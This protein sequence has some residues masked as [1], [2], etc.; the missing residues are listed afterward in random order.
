MTRGGD[1]DLWP[2][3]ISWTLHPRLALMH[4]PPGL[5]LDLQ[6][7]T[8]RE[9]DACREL[10]RVMVNIYR[11][12]QFGW[13]LQE[14]FLIKSDLT[15][16]WKVRT[17]LHRAE[18]GTFSAK[19]QWGKGLEAVKYSGYLKNRREANEAGLQCTM[20]IRIKTLQWD[21]IGGLDPDPGELPSRAVLSLDLLFKR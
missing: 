13:A 14:G 15:K 18:W 11:M 8:G 10:S 5:Y 19:D 9:T 12:G 2:A 4:W 17:V 3:W 20:G 1:E 16:V 6:V 7:L 21:S